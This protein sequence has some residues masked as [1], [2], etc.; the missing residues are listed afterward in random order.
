MFLTVL[1][2]DKPANNPSDC[3]IDYTQKYIGTFI[4]VRTKSISRT[5]LK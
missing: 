3:R 2:Q 5:I 1:R 4:V